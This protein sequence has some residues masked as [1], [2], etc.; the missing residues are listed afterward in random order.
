MRST[1]SQ[2]SN[3]MLETPNIRSE[4]LFV[5]RFISLFFC[6]TDKRHSCGQKSVLSIA[7]LLL[8]LDLSI[9]CTHINAPQLHSPRVHTHSVR[10]HV[11]VDIFEKHKRDTHSTQLAFSVLFLLRFVL[12]ARTS[13]FVQNSRAVVLQAFQLGN[14]V[15]S[16]FHEFVYPHRKN[17]EPTRN[18]IRKE[19]TQFN[20]KKLF[21]L[22]DDFERKI[23]PNR[24][25]N[26]K[27]LRTK[28]KNQFRRIF[29]LMKFKPTLECKLVYSNFMQKFP[30]KSSN[31]CIH[32]ETL[33]IRLSL[34]S[35]TKQIQSTD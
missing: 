18:F 31:Q 33:I 12:L 10:C 32:L 17:K 1:Q 23:Q 19:R 15:L 20:L 26:K 9:W 2:K 8:L 7:V 14:H 11:L 4:S 34:S 3:G 21:P 13:L 29:L 28:A 30:Q 35:K 5:V 24:K 22:P 25:L 16:L 6:S 27:I